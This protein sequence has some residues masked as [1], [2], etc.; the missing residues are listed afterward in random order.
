MRP[1]TKN[2]RDTKIRGC[3]SKKNDS[4]I[5]QDPGIII[6]KPAKILKNTEISFHNVPIPILLVKPSSSKTM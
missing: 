2:E 3:P 6:A 5:Y 1:K 4:S